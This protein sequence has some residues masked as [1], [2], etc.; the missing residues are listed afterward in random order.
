MGV[1][2]SIDIKTTKLIEEITT[3]VA[4]V[5]IKQFPEAFKNVIISKEKLEMNGLL[6]NDIK[7]TKAS[8]IP[9]SVRIM[10][11]GKLL[12]LGGNIKN[13]KSRV[14]VA[15]N[16]VDNYLISYYSDDECTICK[17]SFS[18]CGY[19][20]VDFT[21]DDEVLYGSNG[22]YIKPYDGSKRT[23]TVR[24]NNELDKKEW[25]ETFQ[26]A[27]SNSSVDNAIEYDDNLATAFN[28]AYDATRETYGYYGHH[29][30]SG[31][32]IEKMHYLIISILNKGFYLSIYLSIYRYIY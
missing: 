7:L 2:V 30:I 29:K 24:A 20:V 13:W 21:N 23:Y 8:P 32:E 3:E 17:G 6:N 15:S 22:F 9:S 1:S 16:K 19:C 14:F 27:C 12:K 26:Y 4:G 11:Q 18:C 25:I 5:F 10:K 28:L 31:L